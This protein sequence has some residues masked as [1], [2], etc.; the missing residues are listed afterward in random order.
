M[1]RAGPGVRRSEGFVVCSNIQP[2]SPKAEGRN[3]KE[4]RIPKAESR[5]LFTAS[6]DA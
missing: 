3:Q 4:T 6:V 2:P 1:L 5:S